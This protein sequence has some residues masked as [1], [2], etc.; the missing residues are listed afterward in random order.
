MSGT[1]QTCQKK[2]AGSQKPCG[3]P[4]VWTVMYLNK[5]N[6][7]VILYVCDLHLSG[8]LDRSKVNEVAWIGG[9]NSNS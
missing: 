5:K 3:C 6:E 7:Q 4:S 9:Q 1:T 8:V 2:L